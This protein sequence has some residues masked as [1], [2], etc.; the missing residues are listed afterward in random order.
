[1]D[2]D[3]LMVN[4]DTVGLSELLE[5]L[6]MLKQATF[7]S[8]GLIHSEGLQEFLISYAVAVVR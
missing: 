8:W 5:V 3:V 6:I 7:L 1:M 4:I 2:L